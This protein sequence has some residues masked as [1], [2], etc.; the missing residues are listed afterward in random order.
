MNFVN[1]MNDAIMCMP[2]FSTGKMNKWPMGHN[3]HLRNNVDLEERK[4][5]NFM[6]IYCFDI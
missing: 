6:R 5:F 1:K 3:A 4:K 2:P